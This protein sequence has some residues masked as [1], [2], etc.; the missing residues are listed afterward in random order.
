MVNP[1]AKKFSQDE[2]KTFFKKKSSINNLAT[3]S[4][5]TQRLF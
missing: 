3:G 5:L 1:E 4:I 2:A